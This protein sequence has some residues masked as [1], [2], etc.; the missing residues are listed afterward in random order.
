[1]NHGTPPLPWYTKERVWTEDKFFRGVP[2]TAALLA[3]K[4]SNLPTGNFCDPQ[5]VG[6]GWLELVEARRKYK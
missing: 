1:M 2:S 6:D 4:L 3:L 5:R